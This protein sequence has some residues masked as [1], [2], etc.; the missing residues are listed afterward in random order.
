MVTAGCDGCD[1]LREELNAERARSAE[2]EQE[3]ARLTAECSR[4]EAELA[5]TMKLTELQQADL[6]RYKKAHEAS[7]PNHPERAPREQLQ[8]A[9]ERVLE[10][11]GAEPPAN[12][13]SDDAPAEEADAPGGVGKTRSKKSRKKR[14]R[15]QLSLE[16]LPVVERRLEPEAIIGANAE[17][18]QY[19]EDEISERV[20]YRPGQ[21]VLLR[22]IRPKFIAIDT[23]PP[24]AESAD[25]GEPAQA[26]LEPPAEVGAEPNTG[27]SSTTSGIEIVIAPLPESL[28][29][30]FMADTSAIAHV[31]VS[32][33]GDV[34]PLN[35]QERIS[36]RGGFVLP[37]GT[38]CGWLKA[39]HGFC[40][41]VVDAMFADGK[42]TAFLMATDATG[43]RVLP[44]RRR[45]GDPRPATEAWPP[46]RRHCENWH[47]YVFLAD[48]DHV[49]F[50]YNREHNGNVFRDFLRGY[51]G[52]LLAD[53]AS[54]F[55]VLYR[56][57][58][59]TEH[60][61]WFHCRRP[62]YRAIETEPQQALESLSLIGKLFEID[63]KLRDEDLD[64]ETFT[65]RRAEQAKPILKLFDDW[66]ALNEERVDASGRLASGIGYYKNQRAALHRFLD[67]G[68]IRLDNN[69]SE[70]AL[71]N[72]AL[73][74]ANWQFFCNETGLAWYTT[75]RSLIASCALHRLNPQI[76]IEQLLRIVPHWPNKRV[77]ELAP[78]YWLQTVA[79]LEPRWR[80]L[81]ERP[82][83][84]GIV[85][86]AEVVARGSRGPAAAGDERAA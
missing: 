3:V 15:R 54:V 72:V 9:F 76:Y 27:S 53:A 79:G 24:A 74:Q 75:F 64:L 81:L 36:E 70:Q 65:E 8:L 49:V 34:L 23:A 19:L 37:K 71:R 63:R 82:W 57:H 18:Y 45:R 40:S 35:R 47:V 12:D 6:E 17:R 67:D 29:P 77:L 48:L 13:D 50:R 59:M 32:K 41:P 86:S 33:Y 2:L 68:R 10:A 51:R 61:C 14:A 25:A 22:I 38:Q 84:P 42:R 62:F 26:N 31:I 83:E 66:I 1:K 55:D 46:E 60:G 30:N 44:P 80:A 52:N 85:V 16:N 20:A 7:R 43:T 4:L 73:G 69:L 39:A 58:G 56:D 11:L 21:Y 28:W 5:E 78:K